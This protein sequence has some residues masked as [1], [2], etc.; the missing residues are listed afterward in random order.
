MQKPAG[1]NKWRGPYL[2]GEI[3]LDPWGRQYRYKAI[4][5]KKE[6]EVLSLGKDGLIGGENENEDLTN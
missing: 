3:P 2:D 6:F 4:S 1:T 5:G